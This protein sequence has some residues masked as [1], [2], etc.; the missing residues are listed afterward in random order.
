[1]KILVTLLAIMVCSVGVANADRCPDFDGDRFVTEADVLAVA[2]RFGTYPGS[3]PNSE[4]GLGYS[5]W[6]DLNHD[7][8]IDLAD[9]LV[10][11]RELGPC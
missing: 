3:Q 9:I 2:D 1:M 4:T 6:F 8:R 5:G 7:Q 10:V 11:V